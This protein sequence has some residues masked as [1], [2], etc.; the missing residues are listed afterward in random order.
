MFF[1]SHLSIQPTSSNRPVFPILVTSLPL[2][3]F[4]LHFPSPSA[5]SLR[6][7]IRPTSLQRTLGKSARFNSSGGTF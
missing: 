5:P 3:P 1:K 6:S 2:A 4:P 7:S